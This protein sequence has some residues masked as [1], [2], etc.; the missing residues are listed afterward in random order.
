MNSFFS[1]RISNIQ[2]NSLVSIDLN[3]KKCFCEI[4]T[5]I[6]CF[7]KEGKS[8][9]LKTLQ[10]NLEKDNMDFDLVCNFY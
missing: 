4:V 10:S 5:L 7:Q 1:S 8:A 6:G 9:S 2:I 3:M